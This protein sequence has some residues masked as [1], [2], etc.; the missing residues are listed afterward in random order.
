M[1]LAETQ[2]GKTKTKKKKKKKER[3]A[4]LGLTSVTRPL[5]QDGN[6]KNSKSCVRILTG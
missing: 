4:A 1:S 2:G 6:G 3:N 5:G